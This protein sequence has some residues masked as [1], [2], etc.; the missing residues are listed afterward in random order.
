MTMIYIIVWGN[1]QLF[2]T[3]NTTNS[4]REKSGQCPTKTALVLKRWLIDEE[5]KQDLWFEGETMLKLYR[6]DM[7]YLLT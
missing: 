1:S 7:F 6:R 4:N 5:N 3:N 2:I